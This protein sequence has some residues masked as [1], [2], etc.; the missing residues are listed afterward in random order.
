MGLG[1]GTRPAACWLS[2]DLLISAHAACRDTDVGLVLALLVA[3]SSGDEGER[4]DAVHAL[5]MWRSNGHGVSAAAAALFVAALQVRAA[6]RLR[7]PQEYLPFWP[8]TFV[9]L[10]SGC[11]GKREPR[12][13]SVRAMSPGV[14]PATRLLMDGFAFRRQHSS[15]AL[16]SRRW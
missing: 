16:R 10:H 12:E 15:R 9:A 8:T 7:S 2:A 13:L 5:L 3:A 11:Q 6:L 4:A 14:I 1:R